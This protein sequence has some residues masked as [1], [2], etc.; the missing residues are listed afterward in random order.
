MII[1]FPDFDWN[2]LET[3]S[4][5]WEK[6]K[7]VFTTYKYNSI[8]GETFTIP[9]NDALSYNLFTVGMDNLNDNYSAFYQE[10]PIS[11]ASY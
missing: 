7:M 2:N 11:S 5:Y 6:L 3:F 1:T 9:N 8:T 4:P 10:N